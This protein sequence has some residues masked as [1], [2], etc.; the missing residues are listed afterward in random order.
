MFSIGAYKICVVAFWKP[1]A[2]E[3]ALGAHYST[4]IFKKMTEGP[5]VLLYPRRLKRG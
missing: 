4:R 3:N 1:K 2:R 5:T